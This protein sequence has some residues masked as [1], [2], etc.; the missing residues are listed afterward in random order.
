MVAAAV[1]TIA[2][3]YELFYILWYPGFYDSGITIG[4]VVKGVEKSANCYN[5]KGKLCRAANPP[6]FEISQYGFEHKKRAERREN[7]KKMKKIENNYVRFC[8]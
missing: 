8:W 6:N 3:S 2:A 5:N 1:T 4:I 7:E